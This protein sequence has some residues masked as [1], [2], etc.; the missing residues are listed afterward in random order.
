[1]I[2]RNLHL[3]NGSAPVDIK[4]EGRLIKEVSIENSGTDDL[5]IDFDGALAFPGLINSHDH[6][7]F[8]LFPQLGDKHY[9][10]YTEWGN[11]IHKYY[12]EEIQR[13]LKVP[14]P[15]RAASGIYKNLLAGVTTVVNHGDGTK[16][17]SDLIHVVNEYHCLHSVKFEKRWKLRLNNPMNLRK[18]YV[19]HTG[20]GIDDAAS[21]EIDELLKWNLFN[22]KLIGVHGVAMQ[23]HQ[24]EKL[25]ALV[26]CPQ[27]NFFLLNKTAGIEALKQ[28]T[29][30][31]LGT[32]STL[33]GSWNIWEHLR[34]GLKTN[35]LTAV[36]LAQ[37]L[38]T[39]AAWIWKLNT[40]V[41][42]AGKDADI[43]IAKTK[44]NQLDTLFDIDPQ[45]LMLV[46]HRGRV[47]M[48]DKE[49]YQQLAGQHF[50][51]Q[52]YNCINVGNTSK[53]VLGNIAALIGQIKIY[54]PEA[55]FPVIA[56]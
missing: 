34:Q 30:I 6:L 11:Y 43:V 27:S 51:V 7:D 8:N 10:N 40:G 47:S 37:S 18:P 31:L 21:K 45:Q 50:P 28:H 1:M 25:E 38:S 14:Q 3:I 26:W 19:I 12:Q 39:T 5:S 46:M 32:D 29:P 13:V 48:F 15:L 36:E 44:D 35:Q 55:R 41:L 24:A 54:Y 9:Q 49:V 52:Q 4:V 16:F 22:K 23:T 2:L 20:E 17:T 42:N 53:Y 56:N 33:T